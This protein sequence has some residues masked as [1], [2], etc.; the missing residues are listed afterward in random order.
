MR[1][2]TRLTLGG[3][4]LLQDHQAH[5]NVAVRS[6]GTDGDNTGTVGMSGVG[7]YGGGGGGGIGDQAAWHGGRSVV[8]GSGFGSVNVDCGDCESAGSS[9][10]LNGGVSGRENVRKSSWISGISH[11]GGMES[12]CENCHDM[13]A[14]DLAMKLIAGI[15]L[16]PKHDTGVLTNSSASYTCLS[17]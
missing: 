4:I 12:V 1:I 3:F 15:L 6:N 8:F 14:S 11:D 2:S 9:S 5:V 13:Q 7:E 16:P 17:Y 10:G